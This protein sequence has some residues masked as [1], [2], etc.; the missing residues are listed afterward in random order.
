[1]AGGKTVPA[2]VQS[3][4]QDRD[5][6][7]IGSQPT[8]P[9]VPLKLTP[10]QVA[11]G[12]QVIALG[13]SLEAGWRAVVGTVSDLAADIPGF[14]QNRVATNMKVFPGFSGA[15]F[16]NAR[17]ELVGVVQASAQDTDLTF[18]IPAKVVVP[19]LA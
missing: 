17:G 14:G 2:T 10:A 15:P 13:H 7:K 18:L 4:D 12:A 1:M 5:L 9:V 16:L 3:I 19:A 8:E 11:L 6:A